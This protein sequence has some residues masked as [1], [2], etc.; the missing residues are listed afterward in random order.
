[1]LDLDLVFDF[2]GWKLNGVYVFSEPAAFAFLGTED[3]PATETIIR[4][5][6]LERVKAGLRGRKAQEKRIVR[7]DQ[8]LVYR[9]YGLWLE[10][11]ENCIYDFLM[12][13]KPDQDSNTN[14]FPGH[15]VFGADAI[16]LSS[17]SSPQNVKDI[18]GIPDD[19]D[20]DDG[21]EWGYIIYNINNYV[22]EFGFDEHQKLE[23]I[24]GSMA[25]VEDTDSPQSRAN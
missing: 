5:G 21:D 4:P 6:L 22:L 17:N 15:F 25:D 13:L 3:T 11:E 14:R 19:G 8:T 1:M 20:I 10:Y 18:F 7:D 16:D 2:D 24:E 23:K 12:Y 9:K